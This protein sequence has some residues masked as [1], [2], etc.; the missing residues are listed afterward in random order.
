MSVYWKIITEPVI[1]LFTSYPTPPAFAAA[2]RATGSPA[3]DQQTYGAAFVSA[4]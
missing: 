2:G 3:A 1:A 4:K